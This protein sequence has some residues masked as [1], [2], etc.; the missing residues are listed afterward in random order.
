MDICCHRPDPEQI[1]DANLTRFMRGL[2][3]RGVP[4]PDYPALYAWSIAQPEDFWRET[5]SFAAILA[6]WGAGPVLRD[7]ARMP[8]ARFFSEAKLNFRAEPAALSR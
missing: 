2:A 8:G 6:D 4:V 3:G 5:A 7:P 1:A